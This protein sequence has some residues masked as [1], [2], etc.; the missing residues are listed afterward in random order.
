MSNVK[1]VLEDIEDIIKLRKKLK[2]Y[3]IL[4][5]TK[6]RKRENKYLFLIFLKKYNIIYIENKDRR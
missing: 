4:I 6:R 2:G 5:A 1:I 3:K